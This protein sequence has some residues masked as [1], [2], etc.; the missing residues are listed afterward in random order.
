MRS[1]SLIAE[2]ITNGITVEKR[3]VESVVDIKLV[4]AAACLSFGDADCRSWQLRVVN[5]NDDMNDKKQE[6]FYYYYIILHILMGSWGE[7]RDWR[8][9][10]PAVFFHKS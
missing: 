2:G 6:S 3:G 5:N 4:A 8:E 10:S 1:G 7:G 9:F